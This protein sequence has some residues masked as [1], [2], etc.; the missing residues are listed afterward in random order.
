M[1]QLDKEHVFHAH[2]AVFVALNNDSSEEVSMTF[3]Y[4]KEKKRLNREKKETLI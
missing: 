2:S 1:L 3:Y 4:G